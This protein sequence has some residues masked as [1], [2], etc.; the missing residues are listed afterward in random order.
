MTWARFQLLLSAIGI[1]LCFLLA[2]LAFVAGIAAWSFTLRIQ[3]CI[4][5]CGSD[6]FFLS[7]S[8][9]A[10]TSCIH[11]GQKHIINSS[12]KHGHLLAT[13]ITLC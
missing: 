10:T 4:V 8:M 2:P 13:P 7:K 6:I 11:T 5:T 12:S 3:G 9:C 1:F